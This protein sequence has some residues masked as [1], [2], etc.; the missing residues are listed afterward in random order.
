[1]VLRPPPTAT[2]AKGWRAL[3]RRWG[4]SPSGQS[5][6]EARRRA[7]LDSSPDGLAALGPDTTVLDVTGW[8]TAALG[9]APADLIGRSL[10]DG[11]H[12][13]DRLSVG[14]VLAEALCGGPRPVESR[15]RHRHQDGSWRTLESVTVN[16]LEDP[17]VAALVISLRD[18]SGRSAD[19]EL[20]RLAALV[21]NSDDAILATDLE[22]R[23]TSW[24]LGAVKVHGY[25]REEMLGR[26]LAL[27]APADRVAEI[28]SV[29]GRIQQ[30]LAVD[31][32][33]T[34][35][36]R[37]DGTRVNVSVTVS[38][39]RDAGGRVVGISS[40]TRDIT[41]RTRLESQVRQSQKME[42]IGRL[43]GGVAHDFN[44]LLSVILGH[45]RLVS[46]G[47]GPS[48][49]SS[50]HLSEIEK[51]GERAASLTRQLLAFSRKQVMATQVLDLGV[52][53]NE[54]G[55]IL[56]RLIGEDVSLAIIVHPGVGRVRADRGQI[57]QV[58]MNLAVNARDAMPQGGEL[59]IEV[60]DENLD[61][62][63]V[64]DH[65]GARVG[66]YVMIRVSDTGV[67]MDAETRS[68]LFEPFFTTKPAGEGTG[69]GLATVYGVVKQSDGYI[70]VDSQPGEGTTFEIFLP[71]TTAEAVA[72][73]PRPAKAKVIRGSETVLLVEDEEML[74]S[75]VCDVLE[76]HGYT[77]LA[78]PTAA[79][80]LRLERIHRGPIHL[81]LTDV[82]MPGKNGREL[83]AELAVARPNMRVLYTSG[84]M[85]DDVVR[86]GVFLD[87]TAFLPKPFTPEALTAK[88][89][90]VLDAPSVA[91][92]A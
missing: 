80:A 2:D 1:V 60:K 78:A 40:I 84:Y 47:L 11:I 79:A 82:V 77:V 44:N 51:A 68:H 49:P 59:K 31:R 15:F 55:G 27:L 65:V 90:E 34:V 67:G 71:R 14:R 75:I 16:R 25:S 30:G 92:R 76:L 41:E 26:N 9:Y 61:E 74:R 64:R 50:K 10:L 70:A 3:L 62:A 89:R 36:V 42:A 58:V 39:I 57:E 17:T 66:A 91:A 63:Y 6:G 54:L 20:L 22:G 32:F 13:E 88:V 29:L 19:D 37:K 56:R 83:A 72:V 33:E 46:A 45:C 52:V 43:A 23:V 85:D 24:N 28:G 21:E 5:P 81:L 18:V 69:L 73:K 4:R 53:A 86:R 8:V 35:R 87:H 48:E 7:L 38:P 12:P